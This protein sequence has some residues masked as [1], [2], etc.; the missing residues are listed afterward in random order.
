VQLIDITNPYGPRLVNTYHTQGGPPSTAAF[1]RNTI[2]EANPYSGFH[3]V[4]IVDFAEPR[5]IG[6]IK[7]HYYDLVADGG[8]VAYLALQAT[9]L[10]TVDL[11]VQNTPRLVS[12][13]T[14]GPVLGEIVPA[15]EH[16]PALLMEQTLSGI[17]LY[18]ITI[19]KM[20]VEMSFTTL[21]TGTIATDQ[22]IAYL[23]APGI[24]QTLDL[25]NPSQ[26]TLSATEIKPF[27][28]MQIAAAKGKLVI[29]DRYSLRVF[30]PDTPPPPAPAPARHR[31][32]HR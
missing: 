12:A 24:V 1:G 15:T 27:A 13:V 20:P 17:R 18:N 31:S 16:H 11:T 3:V 32:A 14:I 28:P 23:A 6:G 8:D 9:D 4:D 2:L 25:T 30:G 21:T 26:P 10:L 5:Q 19:S 7:A 22:D 29:A